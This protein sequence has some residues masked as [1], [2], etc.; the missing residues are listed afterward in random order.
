MY[1]CIWD[2]VHLKV[3]LLDTESCTKDT[4]CLTPRG[5]GSHVRGVRRQRSPSGIGS[6]ESSPLHW[7]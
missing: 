4:D 1:L 5:Q 7:K 6:R 3:F 2:L